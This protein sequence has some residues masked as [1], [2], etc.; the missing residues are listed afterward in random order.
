VNAAGN[1]YLTAA[2]NEAALAFAGYTFNR[3]LG[4]G[5]LP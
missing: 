1:E 3:I 5:W 4:Y 2:P